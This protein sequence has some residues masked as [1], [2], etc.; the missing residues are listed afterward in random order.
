MIL[1]VGIDEFHQSQTGH[2][3]QF[4]PDM[5]KVIG[6]L[7]IYRAKDAPCVAMTATATPDEV[8]ATI[9]NLGFKTPPVLLQATPIQQNIKLVT[10]K[11]PPNNNGADGFTDAKGVVHLGYMSQL[12]RI[13]LIEFVSCVKEGRECKKTIIFCRY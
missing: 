12:E 11:R 5:S 10:L 6:R 2:W 1:L 7:R 3:D 9:S 13:I 4:R 8:S